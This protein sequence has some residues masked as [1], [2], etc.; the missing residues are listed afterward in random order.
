M[1]PR[2][3]ARD[4]QPGYADPGR[5][6]RRLNSSPPLL[7]PIIALVRPGAAGSDNLECLA[8]VQ[9]N[10]PI[11]DSRDTVRFKQS[12]TLLGGGVGRTEAESE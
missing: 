12:R 7:P 10:D 4:S 9:R 3:R 8:C 2:R 5:L 1:T 6:V 11:T